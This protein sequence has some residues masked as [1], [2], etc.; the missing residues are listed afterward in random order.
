MQKNLKGIQSSY[1][2]CSPPP[3]SPLL[4]IAYV[5]LVHLLQLMNH[6]WYIIITEVHSTLSFTL[7]VVHSFSF[8]KCK[9]PCI[10]HYNI[11]H[12]GFT[13]LKNALC[14]TYSSLLLPTFHL[15]FSSIGEGNG[16]PLQCSCLENPRDRGAWW[17]A[18]YGVAQS[19]T[20]LKWLSSSSSS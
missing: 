7:C 20:R 12:N 16:N 13:I 14:I 18:V 8:A 4:F 19:R 2:P 6:C 5:S 11:I 3:K 10:H 17:A 15:L 9:M 1:V